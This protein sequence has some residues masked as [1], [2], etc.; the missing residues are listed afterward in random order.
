MGGVVGEVIDE[1]DEWARGVLDLMPDAVL[2]D[3]GVAP[4]S[5]RALPDDV[6]RYLEYHAA[7]VGAP[8]V[9]VGGIEGGVVRIGMH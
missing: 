7:D 6:A 2:F 5:D 9:V 3:G 1:A 8:E 4:E